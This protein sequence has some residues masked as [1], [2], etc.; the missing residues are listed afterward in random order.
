MCQVV[1]ALSPPQPPA[2]RPQSLGGGQE[3]REAT[4]ASELQR[5]L[6]RLLLKALHAW[7]VNNFEG[8]T[9]HLLEHV[10]MQISKFED[11]VGKL[12]SAASGAVWCQ[13]QRAMREVMHLRQVADEEVVRRSRHFAW[14]TP[15][16]FGKLGAKKAA[17]DE[18]MAAFGRDST[19]EELKDYVRGEAAKNGADMVAIER[20]LASFRWNSYFELRG[21]NANG[22]RVFGPCKPCPRGVRRLKHGFAA[23]TQMARAGFCIVGPLRSDASEAAADYEQL[24]EWKKTLTLEALKQRVQ[25]WGDAHITVVDRRS[26]R[27]QKMRIIAGLLRVLGL[28]TWVWLGIEFHCSTSYFTIETHTAPYG[29]VVSVHHRATPSQNL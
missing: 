22:E 4:L 18:A 14:S 17:L 27:G 25:S 3:P 8:M 29:A 6:R 26:A 2:E 11:A 10:Q 15:L 1:A 16:L 7:R 12:S 21:V 24:L 13:I 23:L 20:S 5:R 9:M 28:A 19:M